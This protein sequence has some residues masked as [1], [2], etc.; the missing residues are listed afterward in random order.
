MARIAVLILNYNGAEHLKRFLPS[1]ILNS[2][3]ADILVGD[4]GSTDNSLQIIMENFKEVDIIKLDK[5]YGY[6][7]GYNQF[8]DK[9]DHDYLALVNSDIEATPD[10]LDHMAATL[11]SATS[12]VAVQPKILSYNERNKF[13]YAGAGGGFIDKYGYPFCRGRIFDHIEEDI[14]QYDDPIETFWASGACFMIKRE[15][16]IQAGGFDGDFFAHMEEIDLCWRLQ[17]LGHQIMY[18]PDSKVYHLGGGTLNYNSP[19]KTYLNYRNSWMMLI[20]N[21]A[22]SGRNRK[23][24]IRWIM[25]LMSILLYL[26]RLQFGNVM[27]VIRSHF[28][29]LTHRS[30]IN[31]KKKEFTEHLD[32]PHEVQ[33]FRQSV[34][35]NYFAKGKK[36]FSDLIP[37]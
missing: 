13:E 21:L 12:I 4:N 28:Y 3:S 31:S 5:N 29:I 16:F 15:A 26:V 17:K 10:W 8:I 2:K 11:D 1:V 19:R 6:A 9:V 25:D 36:R 34:V 20:K 35:W 22:G 23:L 32:N 27:A 33:L 24:F 30:L 37:Y 14:G 7:E 18:N